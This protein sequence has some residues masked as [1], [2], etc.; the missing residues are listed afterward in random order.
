MNSLYVSRP[1]LNAQQLHNWAVARGV[2]NVVPPEQMHVTQVYSRTPATLEPRTDTLIVK[3]QIKMLGDKGALVLSFASDALQARHA[4]AMA[5]GASH[6]YDG[7]QPHVTLSYDSAG[8]ETMAPPDFPLKFGPE[9]HAPL[10]EDWAESVGL[11]KDITAASVHTP[12]ALGN[13]EEDEAMSTITNPSFRVAKID[14]RLGLVFGWA[15]VCKVKGEDYYD[16]NVDFVGPHAGERVPEHI[17]EDVMAK[18]ALD[19]TKNGTMPGNEMHE[20]PDR[21]HYPFLFPLT[22]DIAK[23]MG[24]TTEK[25]GLMC[26]FAPPP[27]ILAKFESGEYTGFSIEG[28]RLA[29]E[30]HE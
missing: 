27:D 8:M 21:G 5:A 26:A 7:Y 23:A 19:I 20:G 12:T 24:I 28:K 30:E 25:T 15:V 9:V 18:A 4:E 13:E 22:T 10:K 6:D 1:L 14:K 17:P 2:K 29:Y 11:R 3:R 16:L